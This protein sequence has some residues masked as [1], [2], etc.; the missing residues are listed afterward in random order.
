MWH[1]EHSISGVMMIVKWSAEALLLTLALL[2][3]ALQAGCV[4]DPA[5][6]APPSGGSATLHGV[7]VVNEGLWRQDNSTLTLFDPS[8]GTA[9]QDY[10][11]ASNPGLR[12]GDTGNDI[13]IRNGRAYIA[14]TTSQ[15]VEVLEVGTGRSLGRVLL[16]AN[17]DPRRLAI[18]SDSVGYVTGSRDDGVTEF[19]PTTCAIRRRFSVG[20]APEGIAADAGRVFVANSG[21][22]TFRQSE[23]KASTIS[24]LDSATGAEIALLPS[25]SNPMTLHVGRGN[26][27]ALARAILPDS[28]GAL[29]EIDLGTL[30][31]RRRWPLIMPSLV[32]FDDAAG[33]AYVVCSAGIE[34]I[35][36]GAQ[37]ANPT[38]IVP[39]TSWS[40]AKF[41]SVGV[42]AATGEVYVGNARDY[43]TPGEIM[44]FGRDGVLK[45]RFPCG[46]NPGSYGFY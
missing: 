35:D 23:P 7:I 44:I 26:L 1:R 13:V 14:V 28:A 15:T 24:V 41:Y 40:G 4:A 32:A 6:P 2:A 21:Y 30:K 33:F 36:L 39:A 16:P 8:S 29:V 5:G 20:P 19:N 9:V 43:T 38:P 10:F 3:A 22:G 25:I 11:A 45:G 37:S 18:A 12:L 17:T 27:Y 42:A 46:L 34:M 31:E